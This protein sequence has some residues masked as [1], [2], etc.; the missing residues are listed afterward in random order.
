MT[1]TTIS[2]PVEGIFAQRY[3]A[4]TVGMVALIVLVAFE[5]LA[6]ATAMP[7]VGR[8]LDGL[9]LYALAFSGALAAGM[10]ATVLGGR[11]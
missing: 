9:A 3:R 2:T 4:L 11:W 1:A 7:V 5:A 6:V 10:I 8:E